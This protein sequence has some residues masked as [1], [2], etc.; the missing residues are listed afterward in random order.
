[1][2]IL[3]EGLYVMDIAW[4][5][6]FYEIYRHKHEGEL[7]CI[8]HKTRGFLMLYVFYITTTL[9]LPCNNKNINRKELYDFYHGYNLDNGI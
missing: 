4:D 7:P 3:A 8:L 2:G 6:V 9:Y 1:M 5:R